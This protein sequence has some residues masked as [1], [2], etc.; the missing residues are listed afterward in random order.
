MP[1]PAA[2]R[3]LVVEDDAVLSEL[4]KRRLAQ[5]QFVVETAA[6][7]AEALRYAE[8]HQP[9]LIILDL[10]LPDLHGYEVCRQLRHIYRHAFV[11]IVMLTGMRESINRIGGFAHGAD[12]YLTKP[13]DPA[14]LLQIIGQLLAQSQEASKGSTR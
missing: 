9:D 1:T 13:Y 11:P 6:S 8:A 12:A 2:K 3:I 7:G 5:A 4:L 14:E 10:K